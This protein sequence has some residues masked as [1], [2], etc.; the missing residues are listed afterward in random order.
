[1]SDDNENQVSMRRASESLAA[2]LSVTGNIYSEVDEELHSSVPADDPMW[3]ETSW[4][5]VTSPD[6]KL[7][8]W[9][10]VMVRQ[11]LGIAS[12]SVQVWDHE[13]GPEERNMLYSKKFVH[14]PLAKDLTLSNLQIAAPGP[15]LNIEI[16]EPLCRYRLRYRDESELGMDVTFEGLTQPLGTGIN[17]KTGHADQI[18]WCRGEIVVDGRVFDINSPGIRDRSWSQR[19]ELPTS[20]AS[21]YIWGAND[22]GLAF[23]GAGILDANFNQQACFGFI[24]RDGNVSRVT[25]SSRVIAERDIDGSPKRFELTLQDSHGRSIFARA[26]RLSYAAPPT[27][28]GLGCWVSLLQWD[29]DG[30]VAYGEDHE[31]FA[32]SLWKK[33]RTG[34]R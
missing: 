27:W 16:T 20:T 2:V 25:E 14:V 5:A 10:Y 1:M 8:A 11:N 15:N 23:V 13:H 12:I 6:C 17:D 28:A 33:L 34:V 22:E 7:I 9:V 18:L 29:V 21:E 30:I 31:G 4:W 32:N 3:G 19:A 26:R 24:S